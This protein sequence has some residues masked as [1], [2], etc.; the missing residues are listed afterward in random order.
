MEQ[1]EM[2]SDY[3]ILVRSRLGSTQVIRVV[4]LGLELEL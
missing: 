1:Q 4:N 3:E 2:G